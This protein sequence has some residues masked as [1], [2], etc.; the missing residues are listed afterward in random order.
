[1][2]LAQLG[3]NILSHHLDSTR[4]HHQLQDGVYELPNTESQSWRGP[5][6]KYIS[7][8]LLRQAAY[9]SATEDR[10]RYQALLSVSEVTTVC[11]GTFLAPV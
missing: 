2:Q 7:Y 4:V 3:N 6:N 11:G 5:G 10:M 8:I 9:I 1:M